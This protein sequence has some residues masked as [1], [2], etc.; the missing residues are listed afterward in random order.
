MQGIQSN[1]S[2]RF[3]QFYR[4]TSS[5]SSKCCCSLRVVLAFRN[6]IIYFSVGARKIFRDHTIND[7]NYVARLSA[8]IYFR[9]RKFKSPSNGVSR[10]LRLQQCFFRALMI[11]FVIKISIHNPAIPASTRA[12][13]LAPAQQRC[14]YQRHKRRKNICVSLSSRYIFSEKKRMQ[15]SQVRLRPCR[16]P[17]LWHAGI[18]VFG[19]C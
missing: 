19:S 13:K 7:N 4:Y 1:W 17:Y 14:F 6:H 3:I 5:G 16:Q 9:I 15:S 10:S 11:Q 12:L 2:T 8:R 18:G